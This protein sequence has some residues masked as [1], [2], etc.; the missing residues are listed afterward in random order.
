MRTVYDHP[1]VLTGETENYLGSMTSSGYAIP[2][3]WPLEG[4]GPSIY[5]NISMV[6]SSHSYTDVEVIDQSEQGSLYLNKS[7]TESSRE[8]AGRLKYKRNKTRRLG[9]S[10]YF[11]C[12]PKLHSYIEVVGDGTLPM[13]SSGSSKEKEN[14]V[15][16]LITIL[17]KQTRRTVQIVT[18]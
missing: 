13:T 17:E 10:D 18:H 8:R 3:Q 6:S 7:K 5:S 11:N 2:R 1:V 15:K 12:T 16:Q 4:H 9:D 14:T